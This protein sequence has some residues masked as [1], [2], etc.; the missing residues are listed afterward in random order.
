MIIDFIFQ[1]I[2]SKTVY[3]H[4]QSATFDGVP[5]DCRVWAERVVKAAL[6]A[7][8]SIPFERNATKGMSAKD[9]RA[10]FILYQCHKCCGTCKH[11]VD[12][13]DGCYQC[14]HPAVNDD[15]TLYTSESMVCLAWEATA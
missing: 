10:R 3:A 8:R 13:Y 1:R 5:P 11:G 7:V 9:F 12:M 6:D 15:D 14:K 4:A 2:G